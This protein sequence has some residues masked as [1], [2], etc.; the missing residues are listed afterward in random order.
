MNSRAFVP[1]SRRDNSPRL[2]LAALSWLV[3]PVGW[4]TALQSLI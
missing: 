1:L 2:G 4:E 3:I